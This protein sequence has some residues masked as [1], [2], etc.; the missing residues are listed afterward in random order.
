MVSNSLPSSLFGG[1]AEAHVAELAEALAD[2]HDVVVISGAGEQ[3]RTV[4]TARIPAL[5]YLAPTASPA[6]KVAWH[7]RDQW[8]LSVHR[9]LQMELRRFV[10]DVVL[11]HE[12][13]GL[14]AAVFTAIAN[15]RL[16]HVHTVLDLNL[17]CARKT[18]TRAGEFCGGRC[19][20][21]LFQRA[22]RGTLFKRHIHR[23]IAPSEYMRG[24]HVRAG[25]VPAEDATVIR[26]AAESGSI[27]VRTLTAGRATVGF[28]G[29]LEAHK[30]VPTLLRAFGSAPA[31]WELLVA[32]RGRLE[33]VVR[34]AV[35]R[36]RRVRY[37][38]EVHGSAK[39]QFFDALDVLVV[40]SEWEENA[41]LVL[42][43]AAV[44]GLPA[45]VSDRGGLTETPHARVFRARDEVSLLHALRWF[46]YNPERLAASSRRLVEGR[47]EFLWSNHVK[48]VEDVLQSAIE[49]GGSSGRRGE[50]VR[51]R[52]TAVRRG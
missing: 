23:L 14:S 37:V 26:P 32:G 36:D 25:L 18:M 44:R 30:G 7:L 13:Q 8:L 34:A 19:A 33:S 40:P 29:S 41:P 1:G 50:E 51:D 16:P 35:A 48:K 22:V 27:R 42:A 5:P 45:V 46:I 28:I 4:T 15:L 47:E 24:V 20:P 2:R 31:D 17:L 11:T 9:A 49:T 10:S 21:C 6:A 43:E 52:F 12:C 39:D 3:L 38:G